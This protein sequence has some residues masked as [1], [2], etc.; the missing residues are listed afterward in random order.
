MHWLLK[1]LRVKQGRSL[2][3]RLTALLQT[4]FLSPEKT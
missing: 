1:E 3:D 4:L 2:G